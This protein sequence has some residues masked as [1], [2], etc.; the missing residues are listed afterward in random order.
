MPYILELNK[1]NL[2]FCHVQMIQG[3]PAGMQA[4]QRELSFQQQQ[5][6]QVVDQKKAMM[7]QQQQQQQFLGKES[8]LLAKLYC[9]FLFFFFFFNICFIFSV[10]VIEPDSMIL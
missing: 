5:Q 1:N 8:L 7:V 9:G 3:M 2:V 6:P 4:K 10:E